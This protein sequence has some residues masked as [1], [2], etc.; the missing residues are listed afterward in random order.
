MP[1]GPAQSLPRFLMF[2]RRIVVAAL[3]LWLSGGAGIGNWRCLAHAAS[4]AFMELEVTNSVLRVRL[5]VA[6]R[7]IDD[8]LDLDSNRDGFVVWDEIRARERDFTSELSR[9]VRFDSE[10][11][12]LDFDLSAAVPV[13]RNEGGYVR[14]EQTAK[15]AEVQRVAVEYRLFAE[16]D[17]LHRVL[18]KFVEGGQIQTAVLSP[19]NSRAEFLLTTRGGAV[20]GAMAFFREGIHHIWTGYDHLVFLLAL[21][22][23]SVLERGTDGWRPVPRFGRALGKVIRIVTA[24]TV[25]HSMTLGMA[26]LGWVRLPD[27]W[28]ESAIAGSILVAVSGNL[29]GRSDPNP[30]GRGSAILRWGREHPA[31]LALCFGWIHGF[32]FAGALQELGLG[33]T[34]IVGPLL[35]F[36]FGVETGQMAVVG[37][38]LPLAYAAARRLWYRQWFMPLASGVIILIALAWM[39]DRMLDLGRMPF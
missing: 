16:R 18:V 12:S 36:N 19:G 11:G 5:E 31:I 23:P 22:L 13:R 15:L 1:A 38:F 32:G 20:S 34:S 24:F 35:A 30:E 27:R 28:V 39:I 26:T 14:F 7:D 2:L 3:V 17:P 29:S 25:A 9:A 4:S 37:V 21:L 6:I 10:R 8:L 33:G